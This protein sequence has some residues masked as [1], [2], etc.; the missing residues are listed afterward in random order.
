MAR[1]KD[2]DLRRDCEHMAALFSDVTTLDHPPTERAPV[3]IDAD[4][5]CLCKQNSDS[6]LFDCSATDADC[7]SLWPALPYDLPA[8]QFISGLPAH[9]AV[10]ADQWRSR[11]AYWRAYETKG[12]V[13]ADACD[14]EA[15]CIILGGILE[16]ACARRGLTTLFNPNQPATNAVTDPS[17]KGVGSVW[18]DPTPVTPKRVGIGSIVQ[19]LLSPRSECSPPTIAIKN[20]GS[21]GVPLDWHRAHQLQDRLLR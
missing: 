10:D 8:P 5:L 4:A 2:L 12:R 11:R 15:D 16:V 7:E 1:T 3:H 20:T 17:S 13:S 19:R 21:T 14:V 18:Q 6:K 9:S